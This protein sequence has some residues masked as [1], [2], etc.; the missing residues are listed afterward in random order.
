MTPVTHRFTG[1]LNPLADPRESL[2][3]MYDLPSEFPDEPGLPDEFHDLQPQLLSRTLQLRDY[4]ASNRFTGTD[5]NVY[6]DLNHTGWHKRPDWFLAVDVPRAYDE[7]QHPRMSYV[8]WQELQ[9][10]AVVVEFLSLNTEKQDLGR[11]YG[12]ADRIVDEEM[13]VKNPASVPKLLTDEERASKQTP[14]DKFTVY[15]QYLKVPHYIVYS[16]YT[17]R[18][19]YFRHNGSIYEEQAVRKDQVPAIWLPDLKIGLGVWDD[20]FEELVGPWLRWC[21]AEG[22]WFLTDTEKERIAKEEERAAKEAAERTA[23]QAQA[24]VQQAQA[25][26][27]QAQ[28]EAQQAQAEVQQAQAE[29]QQAQEKAEKLARKLKALGLDPDNI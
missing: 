8:V 5:L 21:D 23:R 2:P 22:R 16:R 12:E 24:E 19:R 1:K 26:V 15:E 3:T 11:F 9:V 27:Q 29:A 6:Y 10:P 14:P 20:Y 7:S 4:P 18:L 17:S 25:E 28:A 13:L